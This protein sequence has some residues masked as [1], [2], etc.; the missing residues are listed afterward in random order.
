PDA[1]KDMTNLFE[2][3]QWLVLERP[4]ILV[5]ANQMR[6]A[7]QTSLDSSTVM[8]SQSEVTIASRNITDDKK[9]HSGEQISIPSRSDINKFITQEVVE[10]ILKRYL[11]GTNMDKLT[12]CGTMDQLTKLIKKAFKIFFTTYNTKADA[13]FRVDLAKT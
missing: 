9:R 7:M 5:T 1:L 6:N 4:D 2:V 11:S 3:C 10:Q 13:K 12:R 8:I